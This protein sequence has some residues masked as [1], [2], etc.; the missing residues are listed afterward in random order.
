VGPFI[1]VQSPKLGILPGE[2][3]ELVNE[4]TYGKALAEYLTE[5]LRQRA[6]YAPFHSCEDWGWWVELAGFHFT[7]GVCVYGTDLGGGRL[8]LYVTDGAVAARGWCWRR[9]RFV[10]TA[11]AVAKLGTD[12]DSPFNA[13]E[14]G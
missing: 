5:K 10:D 11:D 14:S 6:Y 12:L 4:G 7:F 1:R 13:D 9:F 8:D 3:G 2:A